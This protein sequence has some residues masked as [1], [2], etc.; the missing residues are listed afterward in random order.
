MEVDAGVM[1]GGDLVRAQG[2]GFIKE[3]LELDLAVAQHVRVGRTTRSV[4]G[5][6]V[7]KHAVPVFRREI[8]RMEGNAQPSAH[9]HGVLAVGVGGAGAVAVVLFP[10]LHEQAFDVVVGLLQEQGGYRGIDAAG[11]AKH[12]FHG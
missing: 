7:L 4:F 12:H 5:Q 8:A 6:E 2:P 11:D 9:R 3:G 1:A 10:V